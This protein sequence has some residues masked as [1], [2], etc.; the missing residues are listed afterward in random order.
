[1]KYQALSL[2]TAMGCGLLI[3]FV[4]GGAVTFA[5]MIEGRLDKLRERIC[6]VLPEDPRDDAFLF[7]EKR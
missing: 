3:G 4:L 5:M 2:L 1:M 6:E 7:G